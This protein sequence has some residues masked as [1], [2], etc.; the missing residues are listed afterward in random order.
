M[1]ASATGAAGGDSA[2]PPGVQAA[3][4][5]LTLPQ[6]AVSRLPHEMGGILL[7]VHV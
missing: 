4:V 7:T 2:K 6:C 3:T 1:S 5:A